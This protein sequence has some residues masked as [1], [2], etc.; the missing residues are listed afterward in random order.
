MLLTLVAGIEKF[1]TG[2]VVVE[3]VDIGSKI[4]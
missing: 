3:Y 4:I 2:T 1:V